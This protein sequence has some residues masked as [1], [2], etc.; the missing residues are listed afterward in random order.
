VGRTLLSG[1]FDVDFDSDLVILRKRSRTQSEVEEPALSE[2][3]GN[4]LFPRYSRN[5][6]SAVEERRFGAA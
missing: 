2:T 1:A 6:G 4:L 3:E 5:A